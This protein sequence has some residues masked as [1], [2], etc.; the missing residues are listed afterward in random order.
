VDVVFRHAPE[1]NALDPLREARKA[2]GNL[3]RHFEA[4]KNPVQLRAGLT[5]LCR[6][7]GNVVGVGHGRPN[8][9]ITSATIRSSSPS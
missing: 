7:G 8:A 2:R 6:A 4:Y 5:F 9:A 1:R 3:R